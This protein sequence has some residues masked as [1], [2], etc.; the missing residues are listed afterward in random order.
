VPCLV[1]ERVMAGLLLLGLLACAPV[2][3]TEIPVLI[4]S[5]LCYYPLNMDYIDQELGNVSLKILP[6]EGKSK[7]YPA[8][9]F[10]ASE[11]EET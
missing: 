2:A 10:C 1:D 5:E 7:S 8:P 4:L 9:T 6:T 11:V 3:S